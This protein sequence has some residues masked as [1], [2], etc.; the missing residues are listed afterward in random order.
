MTYLKISDTAHGEL[1]HN[2]WTW[3]L[4][5]PYG[6]ED[7]EH[8]AYYEETGLLT[9]A[10]TCDLDR[11]INELRDPQVLFPK[12]YSTSRGGLAPRE[13]IYIPVTVEQARAGKANRDAYDAI[14]KPAGGYRVIVD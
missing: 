2:G 10:P 13:E 4:N 12:I 14:H 1:G 3:V 7:T 5:H 8:P 6:C 9:V 11:D